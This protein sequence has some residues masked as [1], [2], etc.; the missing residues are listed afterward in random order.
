MEFEP[1][2]RTIHL[3]IRMRELKLAHHLCIL[4]MV[5]ALLAGFTGCS[6][7]QA[8]IAEPVVVEDGVASMKFITGPRADVPE[9]QEL[10]PP[11]P[12][13]EL[14]LPE[15]P[16]AALAGHAADSIVY[17]RFVISKTGEVAKI[18][19]IPDTVSTEGSFAVEFRMAAEKAVRSWKFQ[20]AQWQ[21]LEDGK[22]LNGDGAPDFSR[23]VKSERVRVYLD[24]RFDFRIAGGWIRREVDSHREMSW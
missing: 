8:Q 6:R 23:V 9:D 4:S 2:H 5:A 17:L 24:V 10:Q 16:S 13:G 21:W 11:R 1:L 3:S 18:R 19:D 7:R 20:P 15:Y 12:M 22:D 14:A